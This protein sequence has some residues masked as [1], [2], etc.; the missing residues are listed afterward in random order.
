MQESENQNYLSKIEKMKKK[1]KKRGRKK[2]KG[3][4]GVYNII[5]KYSSD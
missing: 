4:M 3:R 1:K 5:L 2:E